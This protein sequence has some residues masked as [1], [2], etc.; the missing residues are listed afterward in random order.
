MVTAHHPMARVGGRNFKDLASAQ[1]N[2]GRRCEE[3]SAEVDLVEAEAKK[4]GRHSG[5][6]A[7]ALPGGAG[8][9]AHG[10][11]I[12]AASFDAPL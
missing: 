8:M 2:L 11:A 5:L 7:A 10:S 6:A 12:G 4:D 3:I 9:A 1:A